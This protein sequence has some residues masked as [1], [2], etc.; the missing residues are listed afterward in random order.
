[1]L[2]C[3][4]T[5]SRPISEWEKAHL[6]LNTPSLGWT[7]PYYPLE[8]THTTT[9][10]PKKVK[11]SNREP[12]MSSNLSYLTVST[13]CHVTRFRVILPTVAIK[14]MAWVPATEPGPMLIPGSHF[15]HLYSNS[16]YRGLQPLKVIHE[17]SISLTLVSTNIL[18]L[19]QELRAFFVVSGT[20]NPYQ[21]FQ[22]T[23]PGPSS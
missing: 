6:F 18:T 5:P 8:S 11:T 2:R 7:T 17:T 16:L 1:M 20:R 9:A 19:L 22:F 4:L 12:G 14:A 23:L 21:G 3:C 15:F 13:G 10:N